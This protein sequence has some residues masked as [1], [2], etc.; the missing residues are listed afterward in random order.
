MSHGLHFDMPAAQY[1]ADPCEHPSLTQSIAGIIWHRT[2][3][4]GWMAHPRLNPDCNP[5][6]SDAFDFGSAAHSLILE[7]D[8]SRFVEINAD[9]WRTKAAKEQR[10][11]ARDGGMIPLLSKDFSKLFAMRDAAAAFIA[12]SELAGIFDDGNAEVTAIAHDDI[13]MRGRFDFLTTDRRIVLDYK[14]VGRSA[15]PESFLRSS[16]F[17]FGYD[18]QA[19]MY[20]HLNQLTGGPED[21]KFVWLAQETEAPY[22]CS[23][24]GASPSLVETGQRKLSSVI[25]TWTECLLTGEWPGYANRIAWLEA[26]AWELSKVEEREIQEYEE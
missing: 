1:H 11:E 8:E 15:N 2:P 21:A 17:Q 24:M 23:L 12:D 18:I 5:F 9:D 10:D 4:H 6:Q 14:T 25:D 19:A 7:G 3:L 26:P 20:L 13:W 16:V 22:A